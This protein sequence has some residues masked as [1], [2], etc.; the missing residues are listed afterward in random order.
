VS[1]DA[2]V[3]PAFWSVPGWVETDGPAVGD[4][5]RMVGFGPDPEQQLALDAL[6]GVDGKGRPA[7]FEMAVICSRQNLK[8]A[9]F[10]MAALGWLFL[11]QQRLIV[12]SA[13]E[14]RTAQEAFRHMTELLEG[15]DY[16]R[17]QLR[18]IHRASGNEAIELDTGQRLIFKARTKGSGR[19]LT[20]NKLILD[21]AFALLP[22]HMGALLPTLSAVPDPQVLYGSSA[23]REESEVLRS[24]RDR[25]RPGR[26]PSL[27]YMEWCAPED[28][29]ERE[30]CEHE[31]GAPGCALDDEEKWAL[32]NP[33]LGRRITVEH[34]RAERRALP[35]AEFARERLGWWDDPETASLVISL[36][37]WAD[38]E[39]AGSQIVGD[40]VF[41]FDVTPSRDFGSIAVAGRR[42]DGLLHVEVVDVQP[43]THWLQ[44]RLRR[45]LVDHPAAGPLVVDEYSPAASELSDLRAEGIPV[46]PFNGRELA[47]ACGQFYDLV[48]DSRG[49]RHLGQH[50]LSTALKGAAKRD[51]GDGGWAWGRLKS[52]A[53][54]S[55]LVAVTLA[56]RG[57]LVYGEG[58][59]PDDLT[60]R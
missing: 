34:I 5:A 30:A 46:Q 8:T 52:T 15:C 31:L 12:W 9:L 38:L 40:L 50:E 24:I 3:R 16:T 20:G 10:E 32:A 21:E 19:G 26:D 51:L 58:L 2:P 25:G 33:A 36:S 47:Q 48:V 59:G 7:S 14:F 11:C 23:G 35:P 1:V 42:A 44:E 28:S 39:D 27:A 45:L 41:A 6:F 57:F 29:C 54:I 4:F 22:M 55:P 13:H 49:L 18:H 17:R 56:V 60:V 37:R 53:N 43:G